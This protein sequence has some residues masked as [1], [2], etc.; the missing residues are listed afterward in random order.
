MKSAAQWNAYHVA[1][2]L[3]DKYGTV[4]GKLV[5][6]TRPVEKRDA[7]NRLVDATGKPLVTRNGKEIKSVYHKEAI[8]QLEREPNPDTVK[9]Y[10]VL[11]TEDII[12]ACYPNGYPKN[13]RRAYLKRAKKHWVTLEDAGYILIHEERNG[14]RILPPKEHLNAHRAL[15]KSTKGIY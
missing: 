4:Q 11:S 9:R 14:W 7:Q 8:S 10:P 5:D 15:R 2:Y 6:P 1:C 13:N 3:W 12:L